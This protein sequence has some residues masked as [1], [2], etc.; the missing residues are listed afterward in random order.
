MIDGT[1]K[2]FLGTSASFAADLNLATQVVMGVALLVGASLARAKRYSAH[3]ACMAAVLLLNLVAIVAVMWPSFDQL[4]LPRL[5][6][7]LSKPYVA[8]AAVHGMLGSMAELLGLYILLAAGTKILPASL[9]F[10]RW[11]LWMRI[12]FALWMAVLLSGIGTYV[13]WYMPWRRR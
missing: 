13:L 11:K 2:G 6:R 8:V 9:R 4:V 1:V 5:A 7:H 3:G 10:K 12:E